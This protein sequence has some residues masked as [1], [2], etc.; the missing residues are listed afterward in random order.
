MPFE[1]F[2][3]EQRRA[4]LE[5]GRGVL[6]SA[7][8]GSGKTAVLAERIINIITDP[9]KPVDIDR[10]LVVTFT[11]AAADEMKRRIAAS[12]AKRLEDAPEDANLHRQAALISRARI[13]TIH[14]FCARLLRDYYFLTDVAPAFRIADEPEAALIRTEIMNELFE[15][16][17]GA[18]D[19]A[20]FLN[21][22]DAYGGAKVSDEPLR[23]LVLRAHAFIAGFPRPERAAAE[24]AEALNI[25][26]GAA[27]D[28]LPVIKYA[29][30]SA[31]DAL[32]GVS[33]SAENA[34]ALCGQA[35]GPAE[36]AP[37]I[38]YDRDFAARALALEGPSFAEFYDLFAAYAPG[39]LSPKKKTT[40][41]RLAAAAKNTRDDIKGAINGVKARFF[42]LPPER[43]AGEFQ[44]LSGPAAELIRLAARFERAFSAEKRRR[45]IVDFADLEHYAVR[46]LLDEASPAAAEQR[47]IFHEIIT[48]EYQDTNPLQ[49]MI[50]NA[51]SAEG[52]ANRFMVGDVKQ[53]VYRF[54]RA[55]PGIF[56]EKYKTFHTGPEPGGLRIDLSRNF[57]SRASVL[58]AAN[59]VFSRLMR[60]DFGG[61]EYDENA[62]LRAGAQFP[63]PP[64]GRSAADGVELAILERAD[65]PAGE[66]EDEDAGQ[67]GETGEEAGEE[68]DELD[69]SE[70]TDIELE[71]AYIAR[72]IAG[73]TAPGSGLLVSGG[74]SGG[75]RPA[76]RGDIAILTRTRSA[77]RAIAD[78]LQKRGVPVFSESEGGFFDTL[79]ISVMLSLLQIIDNPLQER[80]LVTALH[81]PVFAFDNNELIE[82]RLFDRGIQYYDAVK[83]YAAGG[84]NENLRAKAAD[85]L[86][87]LEKWRD[88]AVFTPI[89]AL[90]DY[91]YAETGYYAFAGTMP[92]GG[93]RQSNLRK[94][95][96]YAENYEK[97][98]Y[99]GFFHFVRY[100]H[101]LKK[102]A[103]DVEGARAEAENADL[104]R[105]MTI[106]K[107]KGLEF[108]IVFVSSLGRAFNNADAREDV[109]F[110]RDFGLGMKYIDT[111]LRVKY[112]T[113]CHSAAADKLA[114]ENR[115]EELRV[116]YV[117]M[118]RAK[119]LLILTGVCK[120]FE[121][122]RETARSAAGITNSRMLKSKSLL[123]Y[124]LMALEGHGGYRRALGAAETGRDTN[125]AA[126][127]FSLISKYETPPVSAAEAKTAAEPP[128]NDGAPEASDF[129]AWRYP[130]A[131][132]TKIHSKISISEIKRFYHAELFG[133]AGQ[134]RADAPRAKAAPRPAFLSGGKG[135]S[136]AERG[137]ILHTVMEHLDVK[138][139]TARADVEA[140]IARCVDSGILT[141]EEAAAVPV[142]RIMAFISSPLAE[143]MRR[144]PGV[145][146]ETPFVIALPV[147][148][149]YN[150]P[151]Y[152]SIGP[153]ETV[154]VHGIID[155]FFEENGGVVLVDYKTGYLDLADGGAGAA[156]AERRYGPQMAVYRHALEKS[157]GL[158]VLECMLYFFAANVEVK[159]N[160]IKI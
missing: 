24:Y 21:L 77:A 158:P 34:L 57:R 71:S 5:R 53:S 49:E 123:D 10:L 114:R 145:K 97:T 148:A 73:I 72:R 120:D 98:S 87:K 39:R 54:R 105:V 95:A 14:A 134:P 81:S 48:D 2:T 46:I 55:E 96:E 104:V 116:L 64:D 58:D 92:S 84:A 27:L 13:M 159:I 117:A 132:L 15:A 30:S 113:L 156:D 85:F 91:L 138:A 94:L 154:L 110:D 147:G 106:H 43:M 16:E 80:H 9:V 61:I 88:K 135:F 50:L 119:E 100:I 86:A 118:T 78:F 137:T 60:A 160:P 7:A 47:R 22:V 74:A 142:G 52:G 146:K 66:D 1:N 102:L 140:L 56:L 18:E 67:G 150:S 99:S 157:L 125:E 83:G 3:P 149:A 40:D 79:E 136:A 153:G 69:A 32:S 6:V 11:K 31:R 90:L 122:L 129:S 26:D 28:E 62:R 151:E 25:P 76:R 155:C 128:E 65:G 103:A 45:N 112:P 152:N 29:K 51:V 111:N 17:Y 124:V 20:A 127:T 41:E 44:R 93:P 143:R 107:S 33:A 130:Y 133:D 8:A 121:K 38:E 75:Y 131:E 59:Y 89:S 23:G 12:L 115:E 42:Y 70:L 36:Y 68:A 109:L 126:I 139:H 82:M 19:N 141:A 101:K 144:S 63:A 35:G 108:P 37:A 4:V